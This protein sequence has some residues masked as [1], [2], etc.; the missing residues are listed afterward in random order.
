MHH[1]RNSPE[2]VPIVRTLVGGEPF[3]PEV[4]ALVELHGKVLSAVAVLVQAPG[5]AGAVKH[6]GGH[7]RGQ[8]RVLVGV[9]DGCLL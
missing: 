9:W 4:G 5:P 6:V 7:Q 2:G 8:H 1:N 3:R